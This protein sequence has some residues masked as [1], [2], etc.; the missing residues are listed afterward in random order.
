MSMI[1][2][3]LRLTSAELARTIEDPAWALELA[4]QDEDETDEPSPESARHFTTYKTWDMLRFLLQRAG[5]PVDIVFGEEPFT[6][7]D[8][9]YG[10]PRYL[11]S[12][13]VRTAA[14]A[15]SSTTYDD[16]VR[17]VNPAELDTATVYPTG[18]WDE[19]DSLE[20]ARGYY[21]SL[22]RFFAT[23]ADDGD[24]MLIWLD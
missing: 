18:G 16:L 4:E 7:D 9:G 11:T 24:A 5:F 14:D 15:L 1:G 6:D 21:G 20:W 12:E 23:A 22:I 3:Y 13:R 17:G 19:P 8:W 2:E 10:P